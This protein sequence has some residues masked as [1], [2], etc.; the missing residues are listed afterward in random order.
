MNPEVTLTVCDDYGRTRQVVVE[1]KR[2]TIGR[3]PENDLAI[4][5]SSLSRRHAVIENFDGVVQ[6]SDCGSQNGTDVNGSP[7]MAGAVL[8]DGDVIR[9][10][11]VCE[12]EVLISAPDRTSA[13]VERSTRMTHSTQNSANVPKAGGAQGVRQSIRG[14]AGQ[15]RV[16]ESW[17]GIPGAHLLAVTLGVF[18]I[19]GAGGLLLFILNQARNQR[20]QTNRQ[21]TTANNDSRF[22]PQNPQTSDSPTADSTPRLD[23]ETGTGT[24]TGTAGIAQ[25]EA[26]AAGVM[27]RISSDDKTYSFSEKAL[28]DIARKVN[29]YKISSSLAGNLTTIQRSGPAFGALARRE[30]I[31]PGLLIY[32]VLTDLEANRSGGDPR[33]IAQGV[34]AD[35]AALR[36][37]FGTNDADSSLLIIAA[38]KMGRG[39]KRSHPLLATIRRLVRNPL[40]QRNIWYLNDHAGLDSSVYDFVVSFLALGVIAQ[41]PSQFGVAAPPL[42]F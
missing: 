17:L 33:A 11:G 5:N 15:Q 28:E 9:L 31:E 29:Q 25:V 8:H 20:R 22:P 30:G 34:I 3:T 1:S 39:E 6:V 36:A 2:F 4:D 27:K 32:V 26:A 19:L 42:V 12:I 16:A 18:V 38:Y 13:G 23:G 14:N 37:T 41:D 7:I 40:T 24:G 10:A 35:L 21:Q